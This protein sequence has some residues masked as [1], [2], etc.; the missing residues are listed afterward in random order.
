MNIAPAT[1]SRGFDLEPRDYQL[2]VTA[3]GRFPWVETLHLLPDSHIVRK[4]LFQ[5]PP[6]E[7]FTDAFGAD[8]SAR[9]RAIVDAPD[10]NVDDSH[11]T[12]CKTGT[13][14]I[15]AKLAPN[16]QFVIAYERPFSTRNFE[17]LTFS[18]RS[19]KAV[20]QVAVE[21][22]KADPPCDATTVPVKADW[23]SI[24]L[25]VR[26]C[27][28]GYASGISFRNPSNGETAEVLIDDILFVRAAVPTTSSSAAL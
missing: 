13:R 11:S 2:V 23:G 17:Q 9:W 20:G 12:G 19:A 16:A 24:R 10:A 5:P 25:D 7:V 18:I 4:V 21:L 6:L 26:A 27:P 22:W 15:E 28:W 1:I 8:D 3:R 14:C